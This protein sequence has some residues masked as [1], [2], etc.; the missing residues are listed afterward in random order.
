M[1]HAYTQRALIIMEHPSVPTWLSDQAPTIWRLPH[2]LHILTLPNIQLCHI[3]Q[4]MFRPQ[5]PGQ[6]PPPRKP[7]TFLTNSKHLQQAINNNSTNHGNCNHKFQKHIQ[8]SGKDD[9]GQ[10]RTTPFKEYPPKLCLAI[11][12]ATI[13]FTITNTRNTPTAIELTQL[14]PEAMKPWIHNDTTSDDTIPLDYHHDTQRTQ[15]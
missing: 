4:C 6:P 5:Q 2:I 11:A 13:Q 12:T 7:T 15:T 3:D 10:W 1:L 14:I 9:T 8:L